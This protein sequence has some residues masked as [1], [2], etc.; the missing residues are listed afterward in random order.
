LHLDLAGGRRHLQAY[1]ISAI[2][3]KEREWPRKI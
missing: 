2:S 3:K 1:L